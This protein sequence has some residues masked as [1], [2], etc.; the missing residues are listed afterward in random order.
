[1]HTFDRTI[2]FHRLSIEPEECLQGGSF[3]RFRNPF[4][5]TCFISAV[6][7]FDQKYELNIELLKLQ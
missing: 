4:F 1:M 7:K 2:T 5:K 6:F 3:Q